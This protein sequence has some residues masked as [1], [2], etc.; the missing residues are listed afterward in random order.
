[1]MKDELTRKQEEIY[2]QL[3]SEGLTVAQIAQKRGI[4]KQAVYVQLRVLI[5]KGWLRKE[6]NANYRPL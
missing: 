4:S 5:K 2:R 6:Y 3:T 1:M